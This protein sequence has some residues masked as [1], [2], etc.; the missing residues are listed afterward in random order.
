MTQKLKNTAESN[1]FLQ[2]KYMEGE[3]YD[4]NKNIKNLEKIKAV[5]HE[6]DNISISV[7]SKMDKNN[8]ECLTLKQLHED[9]L[10]TYY[11]LVKSIYN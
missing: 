1:Y 5:F 11:Q 8:Q 3:T 4:Y 10:N 7:Q 6:L 9:T 2:Y